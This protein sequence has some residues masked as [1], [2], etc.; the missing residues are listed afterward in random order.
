MEEWMKHLKDSKRDITDLP[1]SSW[2]RTATTKCNAQKV[3][4]II[5]ENQRVM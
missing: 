3:D 4:T 5:T 2:P 1:R